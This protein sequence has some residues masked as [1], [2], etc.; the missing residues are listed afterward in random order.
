MR[1]SLKEYVAALGYWGLIVLV[2]I[3]L[4]VIGIYQIAT[5][6]EILSVPSWVWFQIALVLTLIIPFIA[7]H[8]IRVRLQNVT[9]VRARELARLILEVRDNASK[10]VMHKRI[11]GLKRDELMGDYNSYSSSLDV[12]HREAEIDGG[13]IKE[14]IIEGF[15]TFVGF[16][17]T[18]FLA[19]EGKVISDYVTKQKLEL[20]EYQFIGR[21]A[22]RADDVIQKIRSLTR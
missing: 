6:T 14:A 20:D 15:T 11:E 2:P 5:E 1:K 4:N 17:V 9:D 19:W 22:S 18:R 21:M 12:L 8:R 13:K 16:H 3:G 10:A 7:F